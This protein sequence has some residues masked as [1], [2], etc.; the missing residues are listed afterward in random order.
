MAIT[1]TAALIGTIA[2][3]AVIA[4]GAWWTGSQIESPAD[5]AAR[6]APPQPS[7]ILVPVERRVLSS[8]I[9]TRGTGRYGLPQKI[10]IAPSTLKPS[11][12]LIATLPIRNAQLR[13]GDV[14]LTASGRPVFLLRGQAPA[15]RDLAPGI[16]GDDVLQ[17]EQALE[18]LGYSPGAVDGVY[19]Q[20]TADAVASWYG[21]K[22]WEPFGPTREQVAALAALERDLGEANKAK[23][24]A[25]SAA[26]AAATAV[27]AARASADHSIKVAAS[28]L[29]A[30]RANARRL[31]AEIGGTLALEL[32]RAKAAH[33]DS[34]AAAEVQAQIAER[35]LIVLDPRQP[36]TARAAA[37]AKL[38]VARAAVELAR[39]TAR[40]AKEE[41]EMAVQ[42]AERD[43]R[44]ATEQAALAEGALRTV[45]LEGKKIVQSAIDA[46]K[47]AELEVRLTADRA[48]RLT[49]ELA[50]ARRRIGVQV[51]LDEVVFVRAFPVRVDEVTATIG[52]QASGPVLS[53]TDNQLAVDSSLTLETAPL[54]KPGMPVAID[55]PDLGVKAKGV[56]EQVANTPGTRGVDGYH[57]YF[58][59]RVI[60]ARMKID[61]ISLRLTIP[62]ESTSGPVL[63]VPTSALSLSAD[64]TSRIQVQDKNE[65][66]YIVVRPGLS[67]GGYVEVTPVDSALQAGQLVV[68][69]YKVADKKELE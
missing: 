13:E 36:A 67:A 10:S 58:E 42:A 3:A 48:D 47:L 38:D 66:K 51:P 60:D 31:N 68:V 50:A 34:A 18:R 69:G 59:V 11:P 62:T 15:Y 16:S 8:T 49:A 6:T 41:G 53:V 56:V 46:Q 39:A 65:L 33:A 54:V 44:Q 64:G 23:L 12:G 17:L 5:A 27:E 61:G 9:V 40:K 2:F 4:S 63:A 30:K 57:V 22:K 21:A 20:R 35:A 7:P 37:E 45:E 28:E 55:E 29:A 1:R 24:A 52:G 19:D 43:A 32:E 25:A 14:I 26:A